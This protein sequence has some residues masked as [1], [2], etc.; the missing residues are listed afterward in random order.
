MGEIVF[1]NPLVVIGPEY[2]APHHLQ[3]SIHK[4]L[5]LLA[6]H[7]YEVKDAA[8]D[9]ILF[10]VENIP[11]FFHTNS[12]VVVYD[13]AGNSILTLRRK[14]FTWRTRWEVYRGE[15]NEEK[16]IIFSARTSSV[17]QI[18]TNLDVFLA[19]NTTSEQ[20]CDYKMKTS[21]TQSTWDIYVGASC[22]TLIAE[23]QEKVSMW[24]ILLGEDNFM[25]T[26]Q[27][28][29]DQAFIVALIVILQEIV[30]APARRIRYRSRPA[31]SLSF[32]L[33]K[34]MMDGASTSYPP[35]PVPIPPVIS[36]QFIVPYPVDL[37]VVRKVMTLQEGK[38]EVL[39]INGTVMFKIKS[40]LLSIR[41][42]RILVD[43]N[44]T[45]IVTFQQKI[46]TAH[47]RWQAF[48][49]ESTDPKD[50]LFSVKKS[51]LF[52][53]KTKLD[54][55]LAGNTKGEVCDFHIKGSWLERSCVIYAGDSSTIVAQMHKKHTAGSVFL[56]KEHFGVTVYP[57]VDYAFIVALVVIL[58]EINQDRSGED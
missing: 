5:Y 25:V 38:F 2:C 20:I 1:G 36:P 21:F 28:N 11:N 7:G 16:D 42:R 22:S 55:F 34:M 23:M 45:P 44:D 35:E 30:R 26:L 47:R 24:S 50:L 27:P 53:L 40:K 6:G 51:S 33:H 39:D 14:A 12:K 56:G 9:T 37:A 48:R 54:V 46:L 19:G 57:N 17:F 49:G 52:Q 3:I 29:V 10:K 4:K 15:S 41:D 32:D 13:P 8:N 18:S 58:E 31:L 43:T